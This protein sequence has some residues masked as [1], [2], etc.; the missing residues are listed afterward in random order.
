MVNG[1][2]FKTV[3]YGISLIVL[4][5]LCIFVCTKYYMP[6]YETYDCTIDVIHE[7]YIKYHF[8]NCPQK[9]AQDVS[10][11]YIKAMK[12]KPNSIIKC[13]SIDNT[14]DNEF[15][16]YSY[17]HIVICLI[18]I[19]DYLIASCIMLKYFIENMITSN[20]KVKIV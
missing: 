7:F 4:V 2:F 19:M 11:D 17:D 10:I 1:K 13:Y 20:E 8:D 3:L 9:Y 6:K 14:C 5:N 12:P 18:I 16:L 15:Y